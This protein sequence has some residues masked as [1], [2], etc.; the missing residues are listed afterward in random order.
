MK[1][2]LVPKT[3]WLWLALLATPALS[4]AQTPAHTADTTADREPDM[5][6]FILVT[7]EPHPIVPIGE[8]V[9]YPDSARKAGIEGKVTLTALI[10]KDGSVSKV[11]VV[12]GAVPMLDSE[13][14]RAFRRAKFT[15]AMDDGK[16]V[17]VWMSQSVSFKMQDAIKPTGSPADTPSLRPSRP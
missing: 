11:V 14:V 10:E 7:E 2:T 16:P 8:L 12:R 9:Q 3:C 13:A 1:T 4:H 5:D 6:D 17:R 15:P